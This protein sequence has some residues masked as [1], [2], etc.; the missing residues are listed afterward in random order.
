MAMDTRNSYL[1]AGQRYGRFRLPD[2]RLDDHVTIMAVSRARLGS[3]WI[4]F[5]GPDG[6]VYFRPATQFQT[7]VATGE[8][9]PLTMGPVASS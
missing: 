4:T 7:A 5:R 6:R 1:A 8:L 3:V 9:V 2:R